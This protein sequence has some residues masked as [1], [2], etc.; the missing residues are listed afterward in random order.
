[1]VDRNPHTDMSIGMESDMLKR[2]R[3]WFIASVVLFLVLA[4]LSIQF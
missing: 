4:P 2:M 3:L 1:M